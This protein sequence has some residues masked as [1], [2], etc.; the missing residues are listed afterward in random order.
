[1]DAGKIK[2]IGIY[3]APFHPHNIEQNLIFV[4]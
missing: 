1:M 4:S 3:P 2:D